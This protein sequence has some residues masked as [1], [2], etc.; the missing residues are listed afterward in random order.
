MPGQSRL[1]FNILYIVPICAVLIV[2]FQ[3]CS[4][5]FDSYSA[6]NA[7][8]STTTNSGTPSPSAENAAGSS[9]GCSSS[10]GIAQNFPCSMYFNQAV[11]TISLTQAQRNYSD[12]LINGFA[13]RGGWGNSNIF[14]VDFSI[15]VLETTAN[16][17]TFYDFDT[18]AS[19]TDSD[20]LTRVPSPPSG[21]HA[22]FESSSGA[23][24]DGGDCHYLVLD[25]SNKKLYEFY[26][27][28]VNGNTLSNAGDGGAVV[29]P[30]EKTW[31]ESIRGDVCT[32]ADAGGFSIGAMLFSAEE[33][34]AGAINHAIR[35]ILPNNRIAYRTYVRPA[36][37]TTGNT[38]GWAPA[39]TSD[40]TE[41]P[42]ADSSLE[43]GLPYGTRLRLKSSFDISTLSAS[44]QVVARALKKYGMILADG[45]NIALTAK[46]D[47]NSPVKY[48]DLGFNARSLASL[49]VTD[50]EVSPPAQ[51]KAFPPGLSFQPTI[52]GPMIKVKYLDCY[53][54]E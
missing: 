4:N 54:N 52:I 26:R 28:T 44:A 49:K 11:D 5:G 46:S 50:F 38:S 53:R 22:G 41:S 42:F 35:F 19:W 16:H 15:D 27:A 48:S 17:S 43:P 14:Q 3:N 30:F 25:K 8:N 2:A 23:V 12:H 21:S 47:L 13:A 18:S 40:L 51:P 31:T 45:G 6:A 24:C 32:S 20:T 7:D 39:P 29:W 34:K 1:P 10:S 36:T 9:A 33:I 37:H